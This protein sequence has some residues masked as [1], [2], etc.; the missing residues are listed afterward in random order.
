MRTE[1]TERLLGEF[2]EK[3]ESLGV[4]VQRVTSPT[5]AA[6]VVRNWLSGEG[7]SSIVLVG[8][9][10]ERAPG[11]LAALSQH[12][13]EERLPSSPEDM[14]DTPAGASLALLAIAET[15]STLLSEPSLRDRTV[16]ML[17]LAHVIVCP[18]KSL[19]ASLDDAAPVLRQLALAPGGSFSTLV[20]GPSRTADIERVMTI[21]VQGPG[22]VMVLFVDVI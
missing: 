13:L 8:E 16:G 4:V 15:G 20:T 14:R 3:S 1:E 2:R 10:R 21:G 5:E 22:K 12:G 17:S 19:V 18:T 7:I 11:F 6:E 9:L